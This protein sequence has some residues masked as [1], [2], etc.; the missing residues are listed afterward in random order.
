MEERLLQRL[1]FKAL[2]MIFLVSR[3]HDRVLMTAR[4]APRC[5][6]VDHR[7]LVVLDDFSEVDIFAVDGLQSEVHEWLTEFHTHV[8]F[9][10]FINVITI[11][12]LAGEDFCQL[13]HLGKLYI[14][15]QLIEDV[16]CQEVVRVISD[17][18]ELI[19]V[20]FVPNCKHLGVDFLIF[21]SFAAASRGINDS[22]NGTSPF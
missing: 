3:F 1:E 4:S 10:K 22:K 7:H 11:N 8:I 6:E 16:M 12:R 17:I 2:G 5:P 19:V 21:A 20:I 13:Y 15:L 18:V 9:D 14:R